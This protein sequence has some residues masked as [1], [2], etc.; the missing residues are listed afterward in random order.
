MVSHTNR[1]YLR[2][3]LRSRF[4]KIV[5]VLVILVNILDVLRI[6]RN[7][8]D[9]DHTSAPKLSQPPERI[10]IASMHFNNERVIRDHWGPAVIEL[11]KILGKENVF[12]SVYESGSWDKTKREL[13]K[14]A[15]ELENMGVPHRVEISDSTHKDE[16][17]NPKKGEGWIDTP[18]GKRELR[19]IPFLA[20]L[21]N[22]TLQDLIDLQKK[23]QHFDKVLFLNDVVFTVCLFLSRAHSFSYNC[24]PTMS[25][26]FW[27]P[28]AAITLR[29]V[30][31]TF[32]D[33]QSIMIP[34]R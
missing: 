1:L 8:L 3:L 27:V 28:M 12:V 2:R 30:H 15:L 31:W 33:R 16:I 5:L 22:R 23:G 26:S 34:S 32:Q 7:L 18:R 21:R 10:Y 6:H 29:L 17:E 20:K 11:S 25:S 14:M 4:P 19:R 24:R 13:N 9:A